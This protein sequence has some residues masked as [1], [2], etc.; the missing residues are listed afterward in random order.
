MLTLLILTAC[1]SQ[2]ITTAES[3]VVKTT[4]E[5]KEFTMVA[6]NWE[7]AP[8]TIT[9]NQGDTVRI[10]VKSVDVEHSFS[11]PDFKI[12]VD[13]QPNQEKTIEFVADK[14][15]EFSF[16]CAIFCGSGH[17]EMKGKLIIN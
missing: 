12:N 8:S 1:S 10:K 16:K 7:F 3:P 14:K 2:T 9:V 6:K 13:L 5:I 17:R 15:G 4:S 11:L